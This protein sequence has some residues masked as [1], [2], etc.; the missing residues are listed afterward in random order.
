M[1]MQAEEAA[2]RWLADHGVRQVRD[3]WVSDKKPDALSPESG[4]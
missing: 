2:R 3:G 4:R 1:E